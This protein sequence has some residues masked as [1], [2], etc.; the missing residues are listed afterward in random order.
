LSSLKEGSSSWLN[1]NE[2]PVKR[3]GIYNIRNLKRENYIVAHF[4]VDNEISGYYKCLE[5]IL[6]DGCLPDGRNVPI[7]VPK[8]PK[9]IL[10][11][12][13]TKDCVILSIL[14]LA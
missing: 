3:S 5:K 8:D 10:I 12:N 14:E 6:Q 1:L 9:I 13:L 2:S 4:V 7:A 11:F